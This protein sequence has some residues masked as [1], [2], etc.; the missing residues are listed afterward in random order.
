MAVTINIYSN[1]NTTSKSVTVDFVGDV[2]AAS[3]RGNTL[4]TGYD[5]YFKVTTNAKDIDNAALPAQVVTSLSDLAL[6]DTK[7][8][9]SNVGTAYTDI[10]SMIV[11]YVYDY[12]YGHTANQFS[13][14]VRLQKRMKF[15]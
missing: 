8:S 5:Y 7:Q 4:S 11:D 6:N 14:G 10:R 9:A 13:S 1:T 12:I 2:L 15:T 3:Y